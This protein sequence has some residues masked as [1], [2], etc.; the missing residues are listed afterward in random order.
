VASA[1]PSGAG[2]TPDPPHQAPPHRATRGKP[3]AEGGA[4][5]PKGNTG[6]VP[7][8]CGRAAAGQDALSARRVALRSGGKC[9]ACS[10]AAERGRSASLKRI[11]CCR[12]PAMLE[13]GEPRTPPLSLRRSCGQ[14]LRHS[15]P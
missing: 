3:P 13:R 11:R 15:R 4:G 7:A 8:G 6:R 1:G 12:W 2:V 10:R 14:F 9:Q 5:S